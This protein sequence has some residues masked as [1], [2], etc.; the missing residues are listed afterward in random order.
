MRKTLA[1]VSAMALLAACGGGDDAEKA[2]DAAENAEAKVEEK[3][4]DMGDTMDDVEDAAD[5]AGQMMTAD[6]D[7]ADRMK[8]QCLAEEAP[9]E[10]LDQ[11]A[12]CGCMTDLM[13]ANVDADTLERAI[14]A[15]E[16]GNDAEAEE[17][18][19]DYVAAN[20][21]KEAALGMGMMTCMTDN[22]PG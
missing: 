7:L 14:E 16:A 22:M 10:G 17:I 6:A 1:L 15:G 8:A 13:V 9:M 5:Q 3:M 19:N 11:D 21:E 4:A 20:P 18:F 12:L 2:K